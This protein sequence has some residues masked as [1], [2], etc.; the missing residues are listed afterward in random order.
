MFRIIKERLHQGH[1]T[2]DYPR[3]QPSLSARFCGKPVITDTACPAGCRLCQEACPT[4]ALCLEPVLDSPGGEQN[5]AINMGRCLF[6]AQCRDICPVQR[7]QF[8]QNHRLASRTRAGLWVRAASTPDMSLA[9]A[10]PEDYPQPRDLR[11]FARSFKLRQVSAGGCNACEADCNVLTTLTYDLGH[12]GIDF[13][14]SPRH[15]DAIVVTGPVSENMRLAL[16]DTYE[17]LPAPRVVIACG[18]CAISGGVFAGSPECRNGIPED[19]PV[20]VFIPGCPPN[21]WTILDGLLL[22]FRDHTD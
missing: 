20:D 17:A 12:F 6:C 21:P 7:I 9:A 22:P 4:G 11:L 3:Q 1:R 14:A 19:I 8:S 10:Q 18:S 13:V 5:P 2:L 16:W 15:A